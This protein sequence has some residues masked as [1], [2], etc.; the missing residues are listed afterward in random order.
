MGIH[1]CSMGTL[2]SFKVWNI[3]MFR[4]S[5]LSLLLELGVYA[6]LPA[7]SDAWARRARQ[8]SVDL[9]EFSGFGRAPAVATAKEPGVPRKVF[10]MIQPA[11]RHRSGSGIGA[12]L[13]DFT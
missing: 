11:M 1:H 8:R 9:A 6:G 2:T 3:S 7:Q 4:H 5:S 13:S 10:H 12:W